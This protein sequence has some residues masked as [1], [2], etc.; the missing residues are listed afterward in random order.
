MRKFHHP[1][2]SFDFL[3]LG[4][5]E[6]HDAKFLCFAYVNVHMIYRLN[7]TRK[8][9]FPQDEGFFGAMAFENNLKE[10]QALCLNQQRSF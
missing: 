9:D 2:G 4:K 3:I 7:L 1:T 10:V 5:H 8:A 6:P